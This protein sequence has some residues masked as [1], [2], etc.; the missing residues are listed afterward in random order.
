MATRKNSNAPKNVMTDRG[1]WLNLPRNCYK[2]D[3]LTV[4]DSNVPERTTFPTIPKLQV[5]T[6]NVADT[7]AFD[8]I[9]PAGGFGVESF[10]VIK[11]GYSSG[12]IINSSDGRFALFG[13]KVFFGQNDVVTPMATEIR[14]GD[15]L[16]T[17]PVLADPVPA[18]DA[19]T[20][21]QVDGQQDVEEVV[22]LGAPMSAEQRAGVDVGN[23]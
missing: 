20:K 1:L 8:S 13:K 12:L 4:V 17:A 6:I 22:P 9:K 16:K 11:T 7:K 18:A 15:I 10:T 5:F 3:E 2:A 14:Y 21:T 19:A 23:K